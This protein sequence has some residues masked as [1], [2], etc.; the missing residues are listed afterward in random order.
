MPAPSKSRGR[1][2]SKGGKDGSEE[3]NKG[4]GQ[5]AIP[6]I[7]TVTLK[8]EQ[9]LTYTPWLV[10][11][12]AVGDYGGRPLPPGTVF[13]ESPDVW[14]EGSGGINQPVVGE[15]TAVFARVSNF[16]L[17][18]ANGVVVKF[19]WANPSLAITESSAHLIGIGFANIPSKRTVVLECPKR[20]VPIEENGGHECLLA[21]A[22]V[23]G[24]DELEHPMLPGLDRH[25]G[26]KNEY[27]VTAAPGGEF[28]F[29]LHGANLAPLRQA[30][31]F[32]VRAVAA[33]ELPPLF[34]RRTELRDT[35]LLPP[36]AQLPLT[37]HVRETENSY[38]A[39]SDAFARGL[40]ALGSSPTAC[41]PVP[42]I[43]H[44]VELE[45]WESRTIELS[46]MVPQDAAIGETFMFRVIQ[47]IGPVV[48]GGYTVGVLVAKRGAP[49]R[50]KS[51]TAAKRK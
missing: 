31:A 15:P 32:E 6:E 9:P 11:R 47:R 24:H 33:D 17:Q 35:E 45:P 38:V 23:P 1:S 39:P 5:P 8:G 40:L 16:G 7:P 36:S 30:V 41:L 3:P 49:R 27:L 44:S 50:A 37:L 2:K 46:G 21:E 43:S 28:H 29:T 14:S 34:E 42:W 13:W 48:M 51:R 12:Y 20:W 25:V 19:W 4:G 26:Q 22:Y 10:I 18:Q